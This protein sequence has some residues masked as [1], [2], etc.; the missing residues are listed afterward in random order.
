MGGILFWL[1][2][3]VVATATVWVQSVRDM[4]EG[5]AP[6]WELAIPLPVSAVLFAAAL[7]AYAV[8]EGSPWGKLFVVCAAV[9]L[10]GGCLLFIARS[11]DSRSGRVK[12]STG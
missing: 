6:I 8:S 11:G 9:V 12:P 1:I 2:V 7:V 4:V 5:K 3:S 10:F